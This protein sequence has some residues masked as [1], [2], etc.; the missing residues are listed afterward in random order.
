MNLRVSESKSDA[1]TT[2]RHLNAMGG[3]HR[4]KLL[5]DIAYLSHNS[6]I[7]IAGLDRSALSTTDAGARDL[8]I[9]R[10]LLRP[11]ILSLRY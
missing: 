2:W 7:L 9:E 5:F 11:Y 1:F 8:Q 10:H 4:P 6:A 3:L